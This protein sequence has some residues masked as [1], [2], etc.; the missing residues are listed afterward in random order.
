MNK[1]VVRTAIIYIVSLAVFACA[2]AQVNTF[3]AN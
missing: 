2:F 3:S 1:K